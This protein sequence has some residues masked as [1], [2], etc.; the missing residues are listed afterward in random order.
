V[1]SPPGSGDA[2][3]PSPPRGG[4]TGGGASGLALL[5]VLFAGCG[6]EPPARAPGQLRGAPSDDALWVVTYNVNFERPSE[7]TVAAIEAAG[8]DLVFLQETH[9]AWEQA[10]EE[11]LD[12]PHVEFRHDEAEGGMA[13]L[14]RVPFEIRRHGRAPQSA[15]PSTRLVAHTPLGAL[16]VLH[17]HLH[18]PLDEDGSLVVG[19]FTTST[20][21]YDELVHQLRG[22]T[23]DLVL[24]DFNEGEGPAIEHLESLSMAQAQTTLGPPERTWTWDAGATEL[25]GRPDHVF[26]GR[27]LRVTGVQVLL[28]G[29]SDHRPLRVALEA[30]R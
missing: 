15:F 9:E 17:V 11:L 3:I 25:E 21:R 29:D 18:P 23:P 7:V 26:A 24:G 14:S 4:R 13:V 20:R 6:S 5:C 30:A 27:A 19:Y 12:Y 22:R 1:A 16:D 28:R 8:A 2:P 10:I